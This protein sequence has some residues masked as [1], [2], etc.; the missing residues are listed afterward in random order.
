MEH[1]RSRTD[2]RREGKERRNTDPSKQGLQLASEYTGVERR[3]GDRRSGMS[4]RA[5]H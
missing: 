3:N 4:R 5:P 1:R 2:G